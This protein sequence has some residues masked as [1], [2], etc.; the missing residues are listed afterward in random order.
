MQTYEVRFMGYGFLV[1]LMIRETVTGCC[2]VDWRSVS[3]HDIGIDEITGSVSEM[4]LP[5]TVTAL[6][7][8][9]VKFQE[10]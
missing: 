1:F 3:E 7:L 4:T 2:D 5:R 10:L 6:T 9:A 8:H